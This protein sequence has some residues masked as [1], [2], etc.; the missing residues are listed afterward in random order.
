MFA[1]CAREIPKP[2]KTRCMHW[3][4]SWSSIR[5]GSQ[6]SYVWQL[7]QR[8][9]SKKWGDDS[10][11]GLYSGEISNGHQKRNMHGMCD[12]SSIFFRCKRHGLRCLY[13]RPLSIRKWNN[14][15]F[16][17]HPR[18]T[19]TATRTKRMHC[20]WKR[21]IHGSTDTSNVYILCHRTIHC[22]YKQCLVPTLRRRDIWTWL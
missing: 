12:W 3:M 21:Y 8:S 2:R 11:F 9:V 4:W 15:L 18:Q 7:H 17:L 16:E 22:W 20:V 6:K 13:S 14:R 1:L 5:L 19:S 10:M